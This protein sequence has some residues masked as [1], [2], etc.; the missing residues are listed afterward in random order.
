MVIK[1]HV[2]TL[3]DIFVKVMPFYHHDAYNLTHHYA[4]ECMW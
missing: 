2:N 1:V 4:N 3:L